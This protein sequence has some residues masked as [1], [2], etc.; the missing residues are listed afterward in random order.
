[1]HAGTTVTQGQRGCRSSPWSVCRRHWAAGVETGSERKSEKH[2][3]KALFIKAIGR[4][5]S[6]LQT[7][8]VEQMSQM[9][10]N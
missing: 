9:T 5:S 2:R 10:I 4:I 1:M 7:F 3:G 6:Q 8:K